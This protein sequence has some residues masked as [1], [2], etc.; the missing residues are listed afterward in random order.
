MVRRD[1]A[2]RHDMVS[3]D[4]DRIGGCRYQRV[5]VR[6]VRRVCQVAEVIANQRVNSA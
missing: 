5:E 1:D 4:N 6:T 2:D 3:I